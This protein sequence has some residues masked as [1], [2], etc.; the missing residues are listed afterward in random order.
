MNKIFLPILSISLALSPVCF[1]ISCSKDTPLVYNE[2]TQE[3]YDEAI[4]QFVGEDFKQGICAIPHA[5]YHC[6]D[7]DGIHDYLMD[8]VKNKM[9]IQDVYTDY[10]GNI[11]YDIPPSEG[12]EDW[13]K[14]AIQGHMDMV[15][16]LREDVHEDITHPIPVQDTI[17]GEPV[18]HTDGYKSSLGADDGSGL[19]LMLAITKLRDQFNHGPIR[20]I[21]T[22]DEEPG[23]IGASE[24]GWKDK[25]HTGERINPV[26]H[27][28]GWDYILNVDSE[29]EDELYVSCSGGYSGKYNISEC[30]TSS[31][32]Q[33]WHIYEL[34]I[35]GGKG[36][37]SGVGI[38]ENLVNTIKLAAEVLTEI[39]DLL[40]IPY[41]ECTIR[42]ISIDC[43]ENASNVIP[44]AV[45]IRFGCED[46]D[47]AKLENFAQMKQKE[48]KEK[49]P[50]EKNIKIHF[51]EN[52]SN[53]DLTALNENE[54]EAV[55]TWINNSYYGLLKS[56]P[57]DGRP[58]ASSN[59]CPVMLDLSKEGT[60][61]DPQ[62]TSTI[63]SRSEDLTILNMFRSTAESNFDDLVERVGEEADTEILADYEPYV[64]N[65]DDKLRELVVNNLKKLNIKP[66][67]SRIHGGIE[68]AWWYKYNHFIQQSTIGPNTFDVHT[69]KEVLY[70]N[71]YKKIISTALDVIE[72]MRNLK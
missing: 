4:K 67:F 57:L 33:N 5:S 11:W 51:T 20:C 1:S 17:N 62:F 36:G 40:L 68:C 69:P 21:F 13:K 12:C 32:A 55:L 10:Y 26:D 45:K 34:N 48:V 16:T 19:S 66:K 41:G 64:Y 52:S 56:D 43:F 31:L 60:K 30:K 28:D 39:D 46:S 61:E 27:D 3:V 18:I 53:V 38:K 65:E 25:E 24:I 49:H 42:L 6:S 29:N 54:T 23:L 2:L 8:L 44:K 9:N 37:H 71:S 50:N 7:A 58:I 70:L 47:L 72:G 22:A 35:T 63:Y 14:L 59:V 15:W